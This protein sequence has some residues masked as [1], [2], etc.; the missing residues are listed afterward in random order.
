M[1]SS[2]L[3][4]LSKKCKSLYIYTTTGNNNNNNNNN[5]DFDI[6]SLESYIYFESNPQRINKFEEILDINKK[7]IYYDNSRCFYSNYIFKTLINF[8]FN[9][10]NSDDIEIKQI[11]EIIFK[12]FNDLCKRYKNFQKYLFYE[13]KTHT[14]RKFFINLAL[15]MSDDNKYL[16]NKDNNNNN[17]VQ[18]I[19]SIIKLWHQIDT[20]F[21]SLTSS[22]S[23]EIYQTIQTKFIS[24]AFSKWYKHYSFYNDYF[25]II[26]DDKIKNDFYDTFVYYVVSFQ[27]END[28]INNVN[29]NIENVLRK[30]TFKSFL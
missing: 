10:D 2:I 7:F 22:K 26:T 12:D 20:N 29:N 21:F 5:I 28:I 11:Q 15:F 14:F 25:L 16:K 24:L 23:R 9:N 8:Y 4:C 18:L 17:N 13:Y 27:N 19:I 30:Y 3:N 6:K 1:M